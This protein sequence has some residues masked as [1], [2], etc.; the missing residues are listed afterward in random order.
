MKVK[1]VSQYL[2]R[3]EV[4]E[5]IDENYGKAASISARTLAKFACHGGGPTYI[6][7][8]HRVAYRPSDIDEWVMSR[9]VAMKST[10]QPLEEVNQSG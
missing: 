8:G 10:S 9:A 6:K 5:Y 7:F 2:S 1:E 3:S 4:T